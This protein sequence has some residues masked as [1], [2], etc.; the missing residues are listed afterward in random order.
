MSLS[1]LTF[2]T[3]C[4]PGRFEELANDLVS[5]CEA[6][7]F[8]AIVVPIAQQGHGMNFYGHAMTKCL[9]VIDQA[10]CHGPVA[11]VDADHLLVGDI[12]ET[13]WP[14]PWKVA[15]I[16]RRG[17]RDMVQIY[18]VAQNYLS[19]VVILNHQFGEFARMFML[20]WTRLTF[21]FGAT[22]SGHKLAQVRDDFY[23]KNDWKA[24]WFCDQA[25]L[26]HLIERM[27]TISADWVQQLPKEAW[28]AR[29]TC[30]GA[31]L[32]HFKGVRKKG[33]QLND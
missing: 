21:E 12:P 32:L 29:T 5:S 16:N 4:T 11:L 31:I 1:S 24:N 10:L 28:S 9:P 22:P 2:V 19:S 23:L 3:Y 33:Y 15:A 26:N 25:A 6:R 13:L 20:E 27:N 14:G 7:G 8:R 30:P 17:E 18:G